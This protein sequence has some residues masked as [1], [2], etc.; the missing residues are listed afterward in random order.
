MNA[1]SITLKDMLILLKDRSTV[2]Q[3]FILPLVFIVLY[4]GL[5]TALQGDGEE[6]DQRIP[7]PVVNLD[8]DGEIA[9][10][11]INSL[12]VEGGVQ[13]I[14]Y[15]ETVAQVSLEAEQIGRLLTIPAGF[16]AAVAAAEPTSLQLTFVGTNTEDNQTVR[17]LV[18][19][20]ARDISLQ[21][22]IQASLEQMRQMQAANPDVEQIFFGERAVAQAKSQFENAVDRPLVSIKQSLPSSIDGED[23]EELSFAALAVPSMTVLFVFLTAQTTA[24]SVYDEKKIGSFRRLLA[25]PISK[26]SLMSGK[27]LPNYVTVIL[28]V[29]VIFFAAVFICPLLGLEAITLGNDPLA[30]ALLILAVAL[31]ST[32]LGALISAV[33]RTEAQIGGLSTVLLWVMAFLGGTIVPLFLFSDALAAIGKITPQYWAVTGFYDLMVRGL[34]MADVGDSILAL[35]GFSLA[36]FIIAVWRFDFD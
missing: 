23:E 28:Q 18:E 20:I 30:L 29:I 11:F 22:Q 17:L 6:A 2:V 1:L 19:G 35:L 26:S 27:M 9:Q 34:T 32:A 7:L 16:T 36:F 25:A 14:I 3:L 21:G 5:G 13:P 10:R 12:N 4:V 8:P 31:C 24:Q 33:A 15:E